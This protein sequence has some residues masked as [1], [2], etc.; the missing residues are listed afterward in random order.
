LPGLVS[1]LSMAVSYAVSPDY[2][3]LNLLDKTNLASLMGLAIGDANF[4]LYASVSIGA[5]WSYLLYGLGFARIT[6]SAAVTATLVGLVP[7]AVQFSLIYF[8]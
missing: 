2:V 5:I 7:P 4:A 8:L 1:T 6:G 3:F